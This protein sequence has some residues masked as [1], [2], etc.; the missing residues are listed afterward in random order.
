MDELAL[1]VIEGKIKEGDTVKVDAQNGAIS[2][3]T[4]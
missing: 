1:R 4:Q 3:K 2:L